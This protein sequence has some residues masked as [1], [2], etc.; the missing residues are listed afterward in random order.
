[1][2]HVTWNTDRAQLRHGRSRSVVGIGW[3]NYRKRT[4]TA[5][6]SINGEIASDLTVAAFPGSVQFPQ[7]SQGVCDV[8]FDG[9]FSM[10]R[11]IIE[12]NGDNPEPDLS[13]T[14]QTLCQH[15]VTG[16]I[17]PNNPRQILYSNAWDSAHLRYG[18]W[19]GRS[20]RLEKVVEIHSMPSGT[21]DLQYQF[22][23]R[24]SQA[25]VLAGANHDQSP[26]NAA[27]V[28]ELN[29]ADAFVA[30]KGSQLRGTVLRTPVAWYYENGSMVRVPIRVTFQVQSDGESVIATKHIPRSLITTALAA[31]SSLFTDATFTPDANP[32]IS[33]VDGLTLVANQSLSWTNMLTQAA[34]FVYDSDLAKEFRFW[35]KST[36][37]NW[38][39][40]SR[41]HF[42]FD[43]SSIGAGQQVDSATIDLS[44][45]KTYFDEF[46]F[47][48]KFYSTSP[49]SNTGLVLADHGTL[50]TTPFSDGIKIT[51][52]STDWTT[53]TWT[54]TADGKNAVDMEGISKFGLAINYDREH[55][56]TGDPTWVINDRSG[57][58][59][60]FSETI[61]NQPT[62]TVTH[63]EASGGGGGGGSTSPPFGQQRQ[64]LGI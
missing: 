2:Q 7:S 19:Q 43:T 13:M 30:L 55:A 40:F 60:R 14:L 41:A 35:A 28:A 57:F 12:G 39:Q 33:T 64:A 59:V 49:A 56:T 10:K 45:D 3:K 27:G 17:D 51:D 53:K 18:I 16:S 5:W 50:G 25:Q 23:I 44:V 62:L 47:Y 15:N 26:W 1:M 20:T 38:D 6:H 34:V 24:S 29:N 58:D 31:G 36:T 52:L 22:Q 46:D 9:G 63:S 37:N 21:G 42:L 11:H 61:L 4:E 48:A 54:L 32:E 8:L